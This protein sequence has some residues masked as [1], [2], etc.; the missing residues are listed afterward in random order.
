MSRLPTS[1]NDV[2][3]KINYED[4]IEEFITKKNSRQMMFSVEP[5]VSNT[6]P[7]FEFMFDIFLYIV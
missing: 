2:S 5:E 3:E 7:I 4:I 6:F 1:I